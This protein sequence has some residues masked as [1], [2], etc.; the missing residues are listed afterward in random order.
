MIKAC[1]VVLFIVQVLGS[2]AIAQKKHHISVNGT[3]NGFFLYSKEDKSTYLGVSVIPELE[4]S[5][6]INNTSRF[7]LSALWTGVTK[8]TATE[9]VNSGV[10]QVSA[11]RASDTN[12]AA[13]LGFNFKISIDD[14]KESVTIPMLNSF[15]IGLGYGNF[16]TEEINGQA[17]YKNGFMLIVGFKVRGMS[18][19]FGESK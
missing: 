19:N 13:S 1:L 14:T 11:S 8:L 7:Y 9:S 17:I 15:S 5:Y 2:E 10:T 4:Y 12:V 18:F 6:D 3:P 16:Y